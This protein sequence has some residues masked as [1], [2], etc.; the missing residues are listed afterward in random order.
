MRHAYGPATEVPDLL[1]GLVSEDPATREI[2]LDGIYGAVHHQGDV[3]ECTVAAI[4]FLLEAAAVPALPAVPSPW[5]I[6]LGQGGLAA[7]PGS[8]R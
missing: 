4:P 6:A 2:A 5:A 8:L 7:C 1:R 3:Y